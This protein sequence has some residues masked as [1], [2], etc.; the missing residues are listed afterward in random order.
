ML[1]LTIKLHN[2]SAIYFSILFVFF[3]I[4]PLLCDYIYLIIVVYIAV[5]VFI[6]YCSIWSYDHKI[7]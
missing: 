7:E 1:S 6:T 5:C 2:H 4:S 3:L